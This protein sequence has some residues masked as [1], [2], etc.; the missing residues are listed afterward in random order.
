MKKEAHKS[1][2]EETFETDGTKRIRIKGMRSQDIA[3]ILT[4]NNFKQ[5]SHEFEADKKD[6]DEEKRKFQMFFMYLF[7]VFICR[8]FHSFKPVSNSNFSIH[9]DAKYP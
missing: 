1:E 8:L 2:Y 3:Q 6:I 5:L 4:S 7:Y 9:I